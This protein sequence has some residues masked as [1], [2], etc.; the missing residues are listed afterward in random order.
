MK[1]ILA[2]VC[3]QIQNENTVKSTGQGASVLSAEKYL[4]LKLIDETFVA[5][6]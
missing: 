2:K 6:N 3:F 1:K 4:I 5:L